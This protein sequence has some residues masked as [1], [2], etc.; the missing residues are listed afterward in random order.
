M[1]WAG[2]SPSPR[3]PTAGHVGGISRGAG[4]GNGRTIV[5]MER[6]ESGPPLP[7]LTG[8]AGN[9]DCVELCL[10]SRRVGGRLRWQPPV[11]GGLV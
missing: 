8:T 3:T 6:A 2:P 9:Y 11:A 5:L 10:W 4:R 7:T 1:V